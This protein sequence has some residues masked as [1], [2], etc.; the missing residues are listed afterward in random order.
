M[1]VFLGLNGIDLD[2]PPQDATAIVLEVAAGKIDEDDLARWLRGQL[3]EGM[4][5]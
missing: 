2:A 1:I 4:T 5:A 3:A